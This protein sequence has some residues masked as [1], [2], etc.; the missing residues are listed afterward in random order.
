[1]ALVEKEGKKRGRG[2]E[3]MLNFPHV[4][5]FDLALSHSLHLP[6]VCGIFS[7]WVRKSPSSAFP[8]KMNEGD[9][10][11]SFLVM[12]KRIRFYFLAHC[13]QHCRKFLLTEDN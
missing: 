1:M 8:S 2:C 13:G 6:R 3:E 10:R 12:L 4:L 11:K 9:E 5:H 7:T